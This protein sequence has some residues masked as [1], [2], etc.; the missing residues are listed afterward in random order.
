[1]GLGSVEGWTSG[2]VD[3]AFDLLFCLLSFVGALERRVEVSRISST[4]AMAQNSYK[5]V[6][7]WGEIKK[8]STERITI[9]LIVV[10]SWIAAVPQRDAT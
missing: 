9:T 6:D 8:C 5:R 3:W 10:K 4:M 2:M 1:M 7:N